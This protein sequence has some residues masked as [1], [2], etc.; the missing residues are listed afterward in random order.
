MRAEQAGANTD[1]AA[2]I[3][4]H[5]EVD[6]YRD[7]VTDLLDGGQPAAD[8]CIVHNLVTAD[9]R[10][11][12]PSHDDIEVVRLP[13]NPGYAVGM[14]T[15][16]RR[17]L[18]RGA[19]WIWLL[20]HD[21]RL[22]P[23]TVAAMRRAA[24]AADGY[25]ALGPVLT[26]RG[27][28]E[29]F[30][31]GGHRRRHGE[32]FHARTGFPDAPGPEGIAEAVWLDGSTI[33]LRADALRAVGLYDESLY[34]YTEDA[35]LCLRLERAGWRIGVVADAAA[36]GETGHSSRPGAVAYLIARNGMRYRRVVAG[37]GG[38]LDGLRRHARDTVHFVRLTLD[39]RSTRTL[40]RSS[41]AW[42]AGT[43]AGV[44]GFLL[45]RHG[46]PP[47]WLPGLGEMGKPAGRQR[48]RAQPE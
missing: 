29:S 21:T 32:L 5:G 12:R 42:L 35:E 47:T 34:G 4:T 18:E 8:I 1:V 33:M 44:G 46:R 11:I 3:L 19:S 13:G 15:G 20:T 9:D 37:S 25:G 23:G 24:A 36:S 26:V 6:S 41:V 30:S 17:A 16:M 45:G 14:N 38:V 48:R 7:V 31:H 10:E 39:P 40:R 22:T 27:S 43:W 28:G 2:V